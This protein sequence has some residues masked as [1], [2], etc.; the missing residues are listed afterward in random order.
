[1]HRA[2]DLGAALTVY[3]QQLWEDPALTV[4]SLERMAGG[5]SRET[6]SFE[7]MRSDGSSLAL[8][9]RRDP[10]TLPRP[11]GARRE[12]L[13]MEAAARAGVPEP[14]VFGWSSDPTVL[15]APF[16]LM[17]KIEGETIARRILRDDRYQRARAVLTRQCGEALARIHSIPA[18]HVPGLESA[19]PL[20]GTFADYESFGE[21]HP[22]LELGFRWLERHRPPTSDR[23]TVVHG[24]FRNGNLIVGPEGLRSVLDW[25]LVHLGD[26]MEDLGWLCVN[27]WR[28]GATPPVGGFGS[29]EELFNSYTRATGEP[30]D[31][32]AVRWWEVFGTLRWGVG[33]MGQARR[34]LSGAVRSVELAALGRRVCEQEHDLLTLLSATGGS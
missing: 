2:G 1:V 4:R 20:A 19:D 26:P 15:G 21:L 25:E 14:R 6:W 28:F 12:A 33:C 5:A 9:L 3:L 18:T 30:L 22:A 11:D 31:P 23:Q 29:Y 16:L 10:P 8:V 32:A 34:H 24:D 7:A 17:E 13:A 27:A